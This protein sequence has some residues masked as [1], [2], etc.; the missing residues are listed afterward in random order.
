MYFSCLKK[1]RKRTQSLSLQ[2]GE[3]SLHVVDDEKAGE[4][5]EQDEE[6]REVERIVERARR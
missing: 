4:E 5:E 6:D 3:I 2:W 1:Q